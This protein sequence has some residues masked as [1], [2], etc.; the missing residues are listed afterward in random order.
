MLKLNIMYIINMITNWFISR[1]DRYN[2]IIIRRLQCVTNKLYW[3]G[4][5]CS[6]DNYDN[7][8]SHNKYIHVSKLTKV[9]VKSIV[10]D[11][12][13]VEKTKPTVEGL[14]NLMTWLSHNCDSH[15]DYAVIVKTQKLIRDNKDLSKSIRIVLK[16]FLDSN[17]PR[18][19]INNYSVSVNNIIDDLL[20]TGDWA[21][22]RKLRDI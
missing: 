6:I 9:E 16:T 1:R 14:G 2:M 22:I 12:L 8:V 20:F 11:S 4:C 17:N 7:I 15:T 5:L 19:T 13:K 18:L 10:I 3:N 21:F